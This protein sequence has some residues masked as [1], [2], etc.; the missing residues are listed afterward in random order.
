LDDSSVGRS[1]PKY[2][3]DTKSAAHPW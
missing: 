3:Q 1:S 2:E